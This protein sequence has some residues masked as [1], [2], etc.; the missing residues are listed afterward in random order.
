MD[1][2]NQIYNNSLLNHDS[3]DYKLL[4]T[5]V[6]GILYS[7]YGCNTCT[8]HTIY[9]GVSAMTFSNETGTVLVKAML[10]FQSNQINAEIIKNLFNKASA[11]NEINGI[12]IN[13]KFTQTSSGST[14]NTTTTLPT[15]TTTRATTR[16]TTTTTTRPI[17]P[18][19]PPPPPHRPPPPPP[20]HHNAAASFF[21]QGPITLTSFLCLSVSFCFFFLPSYSF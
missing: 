4:F 18:H 8:T 10:T 15:T 19:R 11:G 5:R 9:H 14:T 17:P 20:A 21:Y 6:N 13:P 16:P 2:T 7:I 3:P 1:I 12:K